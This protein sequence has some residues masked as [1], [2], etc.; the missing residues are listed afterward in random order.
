MRDGVALVSGDLATGKAGPAESAHS[1]E[2]LLTPL[3]EPAYGTALRLTRNPADA[4]DLVQDAAFLAGRG[5]KSFEPGTNFRAWFFRI[6][7][8]SFYSK[9]RREKRAGTPV[10][11]ED[12]PELFLF[13]QT[14]AAGLHSATPDPAAALMDRLDAEAVTRA[15]ESL[16]DEYRVVA[17][18]YFMQDLPYQE[19]A[20]VLQV[21]VGTVRS[22]LHRGRRLLQKAL[23]TVAEERG[24]VSGLRSKGHQDE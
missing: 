11:L 13:S 1:F 21:P 18:L 10:A 4:E 23:W 20:E 15:I 5:F 16:P 12:T 7:I 9:Y 22:R 3:L 6:L 2:V 8:N 17:T 14:A 24:I 19:I